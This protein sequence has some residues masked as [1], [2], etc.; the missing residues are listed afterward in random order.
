MGLWTYEHAVT[1]LPAVVV[2]ALL[3]FGLRLLLKNKSRTVRMIPV[4]VV[5]VILLLMEVG[6]QALSF[7]QGYDLYCI[8]LHFCSL[9]LYVMPVFSFYKGTYSRTVGVITA[10]MYVIIG[11]H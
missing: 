8:P 6:K 11:H 5:T 1:L 9:F 4:Q 10:S 2:M 7:K 3:S